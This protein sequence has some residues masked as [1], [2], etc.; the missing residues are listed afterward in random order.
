[1]RLYSLLVICCLLLTGCQKVTVITRE[2]QL[3][4]LESAAV[5]TEATSPDIP[6]PT[7]PVQETA[8][9]T[10]PDVCIPSSPPQEP[11]EAATIPSTAPP[12]ELPPA[13]LPTDETATPEVSEP[14]VCTTPVDDSEET[15]LNLNAEDIY[16]S[17][18]AARTGAGLSGLF[19]DESLCSAA[20]IRAEE[21][22]QYWSHTRL[23]GTN[24][25]TVLDGDYT[26][27]AENIFQCTCD[28]PEDDV[29]S[30][31]IYSDSF[32]KNLLFSDYSSVGIGTYDTGVLFYIVTIYTD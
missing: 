30:A 15:H 28:I 13:T 29:I 5:T 23:N 11:M 32:Q 19:F 17:I 9:V 6:T 10:L 21:C 8:E 18:N 14:V 31:M 27:C 2:D 12:E 20:R 7:S 16:S 1:M 4:L 22:S 26:C 25:D 24:W 3:A